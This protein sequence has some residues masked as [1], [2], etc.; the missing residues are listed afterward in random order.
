M[1]FSIIIPCYNQAHFLEKALD[2]LLAQTYTNWEAIVVDDGS[3]D[4]TKKLTDEYTSKEAR[5]NLISQSNG[6]L[7]NARNTGVRSAKG[8]FLVFLDS[9][10]WI[11]PNYLARVL[12]AFE[13]E[14]SV[15]V[16]G[17]EH[18]KN[19]LALHK[20]SR[21]K[22]QLTMADFIYGNYAPP[23]AFAIRKSLIETIGVFDEKLKSAEDW[24]FW[25]RVAKSD[26]RIMNIPD[27]LAAY[28]YS[29]QSMSRD[30][31]RMYE[32]L[33][34]VFFRI[35]KPDKRIITSR[36]KILTPKVSK[37]ISAILYPALGVLVVQGKIQ[38]ACELF[39]KERDLYKLQPA[40]SDFVSLN[41]YLTFRYWNS[42]IELE[43]VFA[44]LKP[45][46]SR[47]LACAVPEELDRRNV[48]KAI[49]ESSR[50]KLNRIRYGKLLGALV[51]QMRL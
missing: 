3:S 27:V 13:V 25:I 50:M 42:K 51:N 15:L 18:W 36:Q 34:T 43:Y 7:S 5:V 29:D 41:S 16:T 9:D 49:F 10:D 39:L 40:L 44:D 6:G 11:F 26:Q 37:G 1:L 45:R 33:K 12:E 38:E 14:T 28:R 23:V 24:D 47:F 8:D 35:S 4:D 17:Y 2:S 21:P 20:V 19:G 48:E 32:A 46:V 22:Q 30:G 31:Q